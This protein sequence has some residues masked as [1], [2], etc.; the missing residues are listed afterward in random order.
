MQ[1]EIFDL[2]AQEIAAVGGGPLPLVAFLVAGGLG[3]IGASIAAFNNGY[4]VGRDIAQ[5]ERK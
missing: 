1:N 2:D 5:N 4:T 3:V